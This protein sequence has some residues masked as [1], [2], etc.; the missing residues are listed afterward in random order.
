LFNGAFDIVSLI[1]EE[2]CGSEAQAE[3]ALFVAAVRISESL[4]GP[5]RLDWNVR[6]NGND[7]EA[8]F[9][10]NLDAPRR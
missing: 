3:L 4:V 9:D 10:R 7:F 5:F 6:V 8:F 2:C 1:V